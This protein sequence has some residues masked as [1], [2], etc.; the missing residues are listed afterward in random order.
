MGCMVVL[1]DVSSSICRVQAEG[2]N[3]DQ[4]PK[5]FPAETSS[6]STVSDGWTDFRRGVFPQLFEPH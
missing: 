1:R 6:N 3:F 2:R 4:D 5:T